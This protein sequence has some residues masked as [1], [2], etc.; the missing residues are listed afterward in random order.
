MAD[1]NDWQDV[2]EPTDWTDVP[3]GGSEGGNEGPSKPLI[4]PRPVAP[5]SEADALHEKQLL[6]NGMSHG[7]WLD[8]LVR[9]NPKAAKDFID[10]GNAGA[11]AET[12]S[13]ARGTPLI[14][15]HLDE[16]AAA[17]QS[18]S[19]S[20]ADYEKKRDLARQTMD[21]AVRH[22]PAGPAIGS[23]AF[24]PFQPAS[25]GG[26]IAL[27]TAEG[28]S[29][30][31]GNA[32]DMAHAIKPTLAGAGMGLATSALG[33]GIRAMGGAVGD[34]KAD[35]LAKNQADIDRK[36]EKAFESARGAHGGDVSAGSNQLKMLRDA[37]L[38]ENADPA[39][40][41]RA[42]EFLASDEGKTLFNQVLRSNIG[43]A[44]GQTGRIIA[45]RDAMHEAAANLEPEARAAAARARLN[46]PSALI[47]RVREL[48]PKIVLPTIGAAIGGPL[49]AMA[50]AGTSAVLGR[51]A[52]T[53]RNA[54]ADP[55]V[56]SRVLGA[57]EAGLKG[58]GAATRAAA[59][60]TSRAVTDPLSPWSKFLK[61]EDDQQ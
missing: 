29:E 31:L 3:E 37:L 51:S 60:M 35:V 2:H 44:E 39:L 40:K 47:R 19:I 55:Y 1:P 14:G 32:P 26:R 58:L 30:G 56:A 21:A 38:D 28:A 8:N 42:H 24:A 54:L 18:G 20:G 33:E 16:M 17:L 52:T 49:G 7:Q 34:K 4:K 25:A 5:K 43:R 12:L 41:A 9:T 23:M 50:G 57:G 36:L 22:S 27:G 15:S 46:D 6:A 10:R 13:V 48:G 45:S 53:V 61:P 59:P 11:V